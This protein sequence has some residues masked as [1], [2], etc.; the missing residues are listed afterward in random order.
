MQSLEAETVYEKMS[1]Q[2]R[3]HNGRGTFLIRA[4]H[5]SRLAPRRFFGYTANTH[6]TEPSFVEVS[7]HDTE[8]C[9]VFWS[10]MV[11]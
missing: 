9:S 11:Q 4:N 5:D 2:L 6:L 8:T 3:G 1:L 10:E 7:D